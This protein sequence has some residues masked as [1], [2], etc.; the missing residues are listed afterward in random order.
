MLLE[1]HINPGNTQIN[2][3]GQKLTRA[4]WHIYSEKY[5]RAYAYPAENI[6]SEDFVGNTIAF[7]EKFNLIEIPPVNLQLELELELV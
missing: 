2:P 1:L 4:H 3:D 6:Q 5:G 7:L